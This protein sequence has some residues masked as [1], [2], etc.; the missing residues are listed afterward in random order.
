MRVTNKPAG[1]GI[2]LHTL[3]FTIHNNAPSAGE[4]RTPKV[5]IDWNRGSSRSLPVKCPSGAGL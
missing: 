5:T 4:G 3:V 1:G 2:N